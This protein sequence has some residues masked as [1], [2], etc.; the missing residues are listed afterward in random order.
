MAP[1]SC[2]AIPTSS[3]TGPPDQTLS[4][5]ELR[6]PWRPRLTREQSDFLRASFDLKTPI[7]EH[8]IVTFLIANGKIKSKTTLKIAS[9]FQG[10][11]VI[12]K[13]LI[14][15]FR[16]LQDKDLPYPQHGRTCRR[17]CVTR[18]ELHGGGNDNPPV[19]KGGL[20]GSSSRQD[21]GQ[22]TKILMK[23]HRKLNKMSMVHPRPWSPKDGASTPGPRVWFRIYLNFTPLQSVP[24]NL[25]V[26][27]S[28]LKCT[29]ENCMIIR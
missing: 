2:Q 6:S 25:N 10:N 19:R 21:W 18:Q 13:N 22:W 8:T 12:S 5:Q 27:K 4:L 7:R 20:T 17:G 1:I 14:F 24:E 29:Y 15:C 26:H 28:H 9:S 11:C 23:Y 16:D 3:Q